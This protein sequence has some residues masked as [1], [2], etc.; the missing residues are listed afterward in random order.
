MAVLR[1][2]KIDLTGV[3]IQQAEPD[4]DG[5]YH[6]LPFGNNVDVVH[7]TTLD[8]VADYLRAHPKSGVR[9]N[10]GWSKVSKLIYILTEQPD[11]PTACKLYRL[12][13][14]S[15]LLGNC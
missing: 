13:Q 2:E 14:L 7:F 5:C 10:P 4:T 9:M 12:Q 15:T 11:K 8:E 6:C 1:I 3:V